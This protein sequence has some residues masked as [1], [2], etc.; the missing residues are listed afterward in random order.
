MHKFYFSNSINLRWYI[1]FGLIIHFISAYFSIGYYNADEHYQ[2]IGPL[3]RLLN[4]ENY[5]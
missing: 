4:I 5:N 2:V 3:E 1:L